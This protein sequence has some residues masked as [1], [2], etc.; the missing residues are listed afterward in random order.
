MTINRVELFKA[1]LTLK[2]INRLASTMKHMDDAQ[3]QN[4]TKILQAKLKEGKSLNSLL[5]LAYATVREADYRLLGEYPY[6]EQVLG[7]I[8]LSDGK[9]AEMKTGEGKTLAA[10]MPMYLNALSHKGAI[11]VTPNEYLAQRD[12][13]RLKPVYEWLGL[14]VSLGFKPAGNQEKVTPE[15]KRKWYQ[16]DI[17]YTTASSLAFDYLFNNLASV[18]SKQFLRSYHYA[19]IDEVDEVLLD[20]AQS[21][22]IVAASPALQSNLYEL[23]DRFVQFLVPK[24]DFKTKEAEQVVWLTYQGVKKAE[25][26]FRINNLYHIRYRELYRHIVLA[27]R[28]HLFMKAGHDYLVIHDQVVLLDEQNGRLKRGMQISTGLQQAIETKEKIKLTSIQKTAASITFTGLFSLFDKISGMTGTAK[29]VE[30]ELLDNYNLQVVRIPTRRPIIRKDFR[31]KVYLTTSAKL[32]AALQE[33]VLLHNQGRP[34]LLVAGSVENSEI[35]SELLLNKGIPHN[36]L[37]AYNAAYEAQIIK[38]A[39]QKGAV[40]IATNMAGRGTDIKL[41]EGVQQ[42]GGLAVIGTEMLPERIR[43]QLAG[44]AGRQGDP[45]TSQFF[46]SLEDKYISQSS[47]QRFRKKY[48]W[49]NQVD[50]DH[51]SRLKSFSIRL[52]LKMLQ[53][54]VENEKALARLQT[55]KFGRAMDFQRNIF[56]Q[57]RDE[58][59]KQSNL[60]P[61]IDS[62]LP[63]VVDYYLQQKDNW[64]QVEIRELINSHFTYDQVQV[65]QN[66]H[67]KTEI[68]EFIV[69]LSEQILTKKRE[70]MINEEQL[71]RYYRQVILNAM[72]TCWIDQV[73]RMDKLPI[74]S[75]RWSVSNRLQDYIYEK[76]AYEFYLQMNK[77][78]QVRIIESVLLSTVYSN[79]KNQLIVLFN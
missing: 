36:V 15:F 47:T 9:V 49:L 78:I 20:E 38:D 8:V 19:L 25:K 77:K 6:D 12:E 4:Q 39:G 67:I 16:S 34:I 2:K 22:F 44:R 21:P 28:A 29:V 24:V 56:Y 76:K 11:L 58:I 5:P 30:G 61:L 53:A 74:Y 27:L 46:V 26:Y 73:D 66:L 79:D 68:K 45:G 17:L 60:Q 7:A 72:D 41:G 33:V 23:T 14:T 31:P 63:K 69:N 70:T 71:N 42:L 32:F 65:P 55:N 75:Q 52:S 13:Q 48:R 51:S 10:T 37:N 1:K 3:L 64:T 62:L 43:Q 40:T 18:K 35:L 57:Q 54:R 59:L 50:D